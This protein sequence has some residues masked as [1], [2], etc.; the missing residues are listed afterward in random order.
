[1][2]LW[3]PGEA[4]DV[5]EVK[6][7]ERMVLPTAAKKDGGSHFDDE[8]ETAANKAAVYAQDVKRLLAHLNTRPDHTVYVSSAD[9]RGKLREVFNWW[10]REG[11]LGHNPNIRIDYGVADGAIRIGE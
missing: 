3:T 6:S 4:K 9:E 1:M 7:A 10:K 11:A 5:V 2:E 8:L